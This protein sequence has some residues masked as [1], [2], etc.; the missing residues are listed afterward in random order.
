MSQIRVYCVFNE[1]ERGAQWVVERSSDN[2][3]WVHVADFTYHE[4]FGCGVDDDGDP[5]TGTG[6][7][8]SIAFNEA[9]ET[10]WYW[11]LRQTQT[12]DFHA[13]RSGE[14]E[15]YGLIG[16]PPTNAPPSLIREPVSRT[17]W[18][19]TPVTFKVIAW[20]TAPLSYQWRFNGTPLPAATT[21]TFTL[22][23]VQELDAGE[24]DVVI[25]NNYGSVTSQVAVLRVSGV[26]GSDILY[27]V[28]RYNGNVVAIDTATG[29][30]RVVA[31]GL[32]GMIGAAVDRRERLFVYRLDAQ[33]V[34]LVDTAK[35]SFVD[36]AT[37]I[38]GHGLFAAADSDTLY[39]AGSGSHAVHRITEQ[40]SGSWLVDVVAV[41]F[42]DPI[43]VYLDGRVLYVGDRIGGLYAVRLDTGLLEQVIAL[44]AGGD[45]IS[46][47]AGGHLIVGTA[48]QYVYRVNV[49]TRQIVRTYSGFANPAGVI[50]DPRDNSVLVCEHAGHKITRL[51]LATDQ[52][53][54]LTE[55]LETPYQPAFA[56]QPLRLKSPILNGSV[57]TLSW[58]GGPGIKLQKTTNLANPDWQD[59]PGS[60]GVSQIELPCA[61]A[62]AF[63]RLVKP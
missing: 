62:A 53:T 43:G 57:L 3:S 11:R 31:S 28:E 34:A 29:G 45:I 47:E 9:G 8:Y 37:G 17:V 26:P 56:K 12:L 63:F 61:E 49:A 38:N 30:G 18:L 13:P 36:I 21:N 5:M 58:N 6:G 46:R 52:R 1:S 7:W 15:F 59:V 27:V 25:T 32:G 60:E 4:C 44:P 40:P 33:A 14:M 16:P 51:N 54:I 24:Y 35:N 19:G 2:S 23:A 22:S 48:S 20:G 50:V 41:G 10:D 55:F 42:P 39:L